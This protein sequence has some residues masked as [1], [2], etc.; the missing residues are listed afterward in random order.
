MSLRG[1]AYIEWAG[2]Q[3][4]ICVV[5]WVLFLFCTN[6]FGDEVALPFWA[7]FE[8][9]EAA[10]SSRGESREAVFVESDFVGVKWRAN[11]S[12]TISI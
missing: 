11:S 4:T 3:R 7:R 6:W 2:I 10:V 9:D 1:A 12:L 5:G 8:G